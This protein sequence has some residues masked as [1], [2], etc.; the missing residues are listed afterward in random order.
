MSRLLK[1]LANKKII[2]LIDFYFSQFI[3]KKNPIVML[4]SACVSF[5]SKNNHIFLPIEYF[6]KNC[7]FSISNKN[8]IK[9]ILECL[10]KK[11]NWSLE[12]SKHSSFGNGSI[13][14]PLVL[15]KGKVYLYKMWKAEKNILERVC[16]QNSFDESNIK[17]CLKILNNLFPEKEYNVQKIAVALTL[18]NNI[19]FITGG[20]GTGKT[21][22]ILKIII[23]LI[24]SYNKIKKIQLS[25][26][27]GKATKNLIEI[28]KKKWFN[29]YF[30]KEEKK[31]ILLHPITIHQLLG[32]SK[33]SEKILFNKKRQLTIDVLIIDEASMI[34]ILMMNNILLAVSKTTKIIFVGDHNQLKPVKSSSILKD[35]YYYAEHG[36]SSKTKSILEKITQNPIIKNK[37]NKKN[38]ADISDKVCILKK[39]Y[40][41]KKNTGIYMLS[42]AI[43]T[44]KNQVFKKL[45]QNSIK[46]VFFY[47]V[48]S[49]IKY[50][51]MINIIINNYKKFWKKIHEKRDIKEII[52]VFKN[53]QVLCI[54]R[55]GFFG[56]NFINKVL[57]E[58]MYK[59]NIFDKY[60]YI[61]NKLWY[62]GKPIIITENNKCLG[63]SNG[64]I[65]ITNLSK[66]NTLQV[67]FLKKDN[68]VNDIPVE[69]LKKY[70]TAWSMTVHKAQGSEFNNVTLILPNK[71]L[72]ILKKDILYT[73]ITRTRKQLSIFSKK[74]IFIKTI[75]QN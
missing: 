38:T 18:I 53:Y 51:N 36:Y 56:V 73:G 35:I 69:I 67:S 3:S 62:I 8:F 15:Y 43:R 26:P 28:L 75:L 39:S 9:K 32:I 33:T 72:K 5:E 27:T 2:N 71:D 6:E 47:E 45:F 14:T 31:K 37:I 4:V 63:I 23:A 58:E 7:F 48:T 64:E 1:V 29:D 74:E 11:I 65:G 46:N 50:K 19:V 25:A 55:N 16:Q 54:M 42:N 22:T 66:K 40:R 24:K 57:E 41:F 20:P 52:N 44:N 21:T 61:K 12:L 59:T 34:D 49:E 13:I 60:F 10:K 30:C 68:I 70:E 17:T